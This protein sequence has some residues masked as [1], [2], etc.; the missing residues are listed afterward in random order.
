MSGFGRTSGRARRQT[1]S[2]GNLDAIIVPLQDGPALGETSRYSRPPC[3]LPDGKLA[4]ISTA[5][6]SFT[7]VPSGAASME[8]AGEPVQFPSCR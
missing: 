8:P 2:F 4:D 5:G 3:L 6:P 1:R 7:A